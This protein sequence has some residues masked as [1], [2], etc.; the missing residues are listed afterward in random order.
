MRDAERQLREALGRVAAPEEREAE[1]RAWRVVRA[2]REVSPVP[3]RRSRL[4]RHV[5]QV[6]IGLGLVALVVSPAGASVRHWVADRVDPG[7]EH[8]EPALTALPGNGS[9]LVQSARG[10]WLVH[11]DGSKRLLGDYPEAT[12][13][14]H[15][16]FVAAASRHQLAAVAPDGTVRWTLARTGPVRLPS[17]NGPDGFRIAYLDRASLRVVDGDGADDRLLARG[18]APVAPAWQP[19]PAH[20]LAFAR[21]D[22]RVEALGADDGTRRFETAGGA[23]RPLSLQWS[24]DGSRLMVVRP[25]RIE[26]LDAGGARRRRYDAR[27]GTRFRAAR[28]APDGGRVAAI[29]TR[30]G[31]SRLVLLGPGSA[32]RTLFAG[33]GRFATVDWSPEEAGCC[34]PGPAPTSGSSSARAEA[35]RST[36]SATSRRSSHRGRA[37]RRRSRLSAAGAARADPVAGPP[38]GPRPYRRR[39]QG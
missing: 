8:A 7:V 2:A 19:G 15:G 24:R 4:R 28:L 35:R 29:V 34:S 20:V 5:A 10:P 22:G 33:P 3:E 36:R 27:A 32:S 14:P 39:W 12:W 26:L 30:P 16:L 17:W 18:A 1:E 23:A 25:R 38:P 9:L 31:G 13:S 6:A 21:R 37:A 11:P